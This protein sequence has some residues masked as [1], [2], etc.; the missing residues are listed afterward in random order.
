MEV[1]EKNN[2][3]LWKKIGKKKLIGT[4]TRMLREREREREREIKRK[5]K[6]ERD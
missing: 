6:R 2:D 4:V 5:R 1:N 3:K